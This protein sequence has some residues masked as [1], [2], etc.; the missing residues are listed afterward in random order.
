[1]QAP[2][3]GAGPGT[4][5]R[6]DLNR[7]MGMVLW[8]FPCYWAIRLPSN[9]LRSA[10]IATTIA[11]SGECGGDHLRLAGAGRVVGIDLRGGEIAVP[12]PLLQG[13]HR[14]SGRGHPGAE[15]VA[16]VVKRWGRVELCGLE[17]RPHAS[18]AIC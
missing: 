6:P 2:A 4:S 1:M 17:R 9:W 14:D 13:A 5:G 11:T 12:H 15:R 8:R 3:P 18:R 16:K 7:D 10:Q